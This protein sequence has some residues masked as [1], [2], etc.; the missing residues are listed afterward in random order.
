MRLQHWNRI[1]RGEGDEMDL[2]LE[3]AEA[4]EP[5]EKGPANAAPQER[6][7]RITLNYPGKTGNTEFDWLQAEMELRARNAHSLCA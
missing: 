1:R 3:V 5:G 2:E 4:G 6:G 7:M